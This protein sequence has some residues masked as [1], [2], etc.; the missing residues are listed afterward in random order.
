MSTQTFSTLDYPQVLK[1]VHSQSDQALQVKNIA[2]LITVPFDSITLTYITSGNGAGQVGQV[3]YY[4]GG[5]SG[6]L[7]ATLVLSYDASSNLI[8]VARS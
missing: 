6:T 3:N 4:T 7:V 2:N 1:N 8:S 5:T